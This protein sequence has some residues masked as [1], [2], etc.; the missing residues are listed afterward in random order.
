MSWANILKKNDKEFQTEFYKE[1]NENETIYIEEKDPYIKNIDDEFE[2]VYMDKIMDIK[3]D[4]KEYIDFQ[5]LPF[6]NKNN[7]STLNFYNFIKENCF[8]LLKL[9]EIIDKEN[10]EYLDEF[11]NNSLNEYEDYYEYD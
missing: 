7:S 3:D 11:K 8:N 6:L 1:N 9:K 4:F 2:Y 5:A 10:T